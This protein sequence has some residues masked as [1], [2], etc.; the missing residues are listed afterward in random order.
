MDIA[1]VQSFAKGMPLTS[2]GGFLRRTYTCIVISDS[3]LTFDEESK[4]SKQLLTNNNYTSTMAD[5][6]ISEFMDKRCKHQF[7]ATSSSYQWPHDVE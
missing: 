3:R 7:C 4:R 6:C 1:I 2:E 5:Q